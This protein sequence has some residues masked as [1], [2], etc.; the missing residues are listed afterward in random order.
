MP[1]IVHLKSVVSAA[2]RLVSPN[3]WARTDRP[4]T[5]FLPVHDFPSSFLCSMIT[6]MSAMLLLVSTPFA[7]PNVGAAALGAN[8]SWASQMS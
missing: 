8:C 1:H 6:C 4:N 2:K 3:K 5:Y 7:P